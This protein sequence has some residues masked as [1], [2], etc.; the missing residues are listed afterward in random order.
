MA[1]LTMKV[2]QRNSSNLSMI[3]SNLGNIRNGS[4]SSIQ[5]DDIS[6]IPKIPKEIEKYIGRSLKAVTIVIVKGD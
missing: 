3:R 4:F 1:D 6:D 5:I 2:I